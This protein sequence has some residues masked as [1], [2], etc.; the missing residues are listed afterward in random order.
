MQYHYLAVA[1]AVGS[2]VSD[3]CV[4]ALQRDRDQSWAIGTIGS[5]LGSIVLLPFV[6]LQARYLSAEVLLLFALSGVLWAFMVLWDMRSYAHADAASNAILSIVRT[7]LLVVAGCAVFGEKLTASIV[8]GGALVLCGIF[9]CIPFEMY[10]KPK[11]LKYR[12]GSI[13]AGTAA[14]IVDKTLVGLTD[15][16]LVAWAGYILPGLVFV[17]LRPSGWRNELRIESAS[18]AALMAAILTLYVGLGP[19]L[20]M[21]FGLGHMG[22]TFLVLQTKLVLVLLLSAALLHEREYLG[23][24]IA[25][26]GLCGAGVALMT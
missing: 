18:R 26:A 19:F 24:K 21:S 23:R 8:Y 11:G 3:L 4:R 9:V 16:R 10:R 15:F 1:V 25:A 2:A 20:I 5:L 22:S 14:I 7:L 17:L 13:A 12:F 6:E